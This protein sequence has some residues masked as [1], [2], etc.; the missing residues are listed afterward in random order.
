MTCA[1]RPR[2]STRSNPV[3]D[4]NEAVPGTPSAGR[5]RRQLRRIKE[6]LEGLPFLREVASRPC[7]SLSH[8][9]LVRWIPQKG[10][11][12]CPVPLSS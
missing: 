11:L 2:A 5:G 8:V 9:P 6:A 4:R 7:G 12:V 1:A 3:T 10:V